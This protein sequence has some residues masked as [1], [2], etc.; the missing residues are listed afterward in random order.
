MGK[1]SVDSIGKDLVNQY[2]TFS[3]GGGF[4]PVSISF[5][6]PFC[7]GVFNLVFIFK[8]TNGSP[9]YGMRYKGSYNSELSKGAA[10]LLVLLDA[11]SAVMA[12]WMGASAGKLLLAI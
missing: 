8:D 12:H 3:Q 9:N 6:I 2:G 1:R 11:A 5:A 7:L 10:L 4:R